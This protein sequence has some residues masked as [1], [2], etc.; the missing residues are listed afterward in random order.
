[1]FKFALAAVLAF[2]PILTSA[3]QAPGA[4]FFCEPRDNIVAQL[5]ERLGETRW[6]V[7]LLGNAAV[8][9]TYVNAETGSWTIIVSL[10]TGMAC[11][12]AAGE[13]FHSEYNELPAKGKDS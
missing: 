10:P 12:I 8:M 4:G 5:A 13:A 3:Q 2:T 11:P 1:M 7:G 9:E 6:S